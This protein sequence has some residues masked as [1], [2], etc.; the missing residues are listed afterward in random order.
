MGERRH[1]HGRGRAEIRREGPAVAWVRQPRASPARKPQLDHKSKASAPT[2]PRS[3]AE[4]FQPRSQRDATLRMSHSPARRCTTTDEQPCCRVKGGIAS[5]SADPI[6]EKRSRSLRSRHAPHLRH[7]TRQLGPGVIT[8]AAD[9][10][11]S[12][13]AT[14]SQIGAQFFWSAV[15]NGAVSAPMMAVMVVLGSGRAVM[16]RLVLP[17]SLRLLGSFTAVLMGACTIGMIA[18]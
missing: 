11:P 10:D 13:I 3:S 2:I 1:P 4:S 16:G 12:G 8:G 5:V 6:F 15:I 18:L 7:L 9:D 14:Y 17:W